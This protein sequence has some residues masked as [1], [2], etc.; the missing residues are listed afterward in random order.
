M[1][2]CLLNLFLSGSEFGVD[3][4]SVFVF[5]VEHFL[6]LYFLFTAV[7]HS[8]HEFVSH[9]DEMLFQEA[10]CFAEWDNLFHCVLNLLNEFIIRLVTYFLLCKH[11]FFLLALWNVLLELFLNV[12]SFFWELPWGIKE[13][14][15]RIIQIQLINDIFFLWLLMWVWGF[16]FLQFVWSSFFLDSVSLLGR[17]G[18]FEKIFI[19]L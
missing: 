1:S 16:N 13:Y 18:L 3:N 12:F 2:F 8:L 5:H 7:V 4:W 14:F 10:S 9:S 6:S 19:T 11:S 17:W 15:L